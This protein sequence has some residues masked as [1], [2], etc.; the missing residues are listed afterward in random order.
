[1]RTSV[2]IIVLLVFYSTSELFMRGVQLSILVA[3]VT[4]LC[5]NKFHTTSRQY[6]Y[7]LL[8]TPY[9]RPQKDL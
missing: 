8:C 1:M 9:T 6:S 7:L 3:L 2:H 5:D 4:A